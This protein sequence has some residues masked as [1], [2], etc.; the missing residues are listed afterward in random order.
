MP[1][2]DRTGP[3]GAGPGTGRGR[4]NCGQK[5]GLSGFAGPGTTGGMFRGRGL[6]RGGQG[7]C[8]GL[9]GWWQ[10]LWASSQPPAEEAQ[11]LKTTISSVKAELA[12]ME[13]RL[14]ELEKKE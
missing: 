3:M 7:R 2:Y 9:R 11:T 4:G 8:L 1:R 6:G 14:A 12:A 13:A 5:P 10:G